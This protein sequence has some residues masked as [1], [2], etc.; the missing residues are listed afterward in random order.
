M[1]KGNLLTGEMCKKVGGLW[2][3][4]NAIMEMSWSHAI[5]LK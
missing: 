4:L 2:E 5:M 3:V 1:G